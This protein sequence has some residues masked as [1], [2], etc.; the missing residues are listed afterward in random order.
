MMADLMSDHV[1]IGKVAASS[2][3][4]LHVL[5]ERGVQIDLLVLRTI[6][7]SHGRASKAAGGTGRAREQD[8]YR[9]PVGAI[10]LLRQDLR[11]DIL[12]LAEDPRHEPAHP[13]I[14]R[15]GRSLARLAG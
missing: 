6:E 2:H 10:C 7:W 13:I 12:G 5:K 15:P 4:A 14:R 11:P 9:L 1:G 8:Q 3:T